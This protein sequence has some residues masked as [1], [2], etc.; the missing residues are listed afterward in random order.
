MAELGGFCGGR[1]TDEQWAAVEPHLL[2]KTV[3]D[4]G[5]GNLELAYKVKL[6]GGARKVIA[7]DCDEMPKPEFGGVKLKGIETHRSHFHKFM[8]PPGMLDVVLISWP[9]NWDL[10]IMHLL[11]KASKIIYLGCNTGGTACGDSVLFEHL[12]GREVLAHVPDRYNV[13]T[14]Y[15]SMGATRELLPEEH[16]A[17]NDYKIWSYTDIYGE[18]ECTPSPST[19]EPET[20][21]AP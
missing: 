3:F 9:C 19:T 5:A 20:P 4:L 7:I 14:T 18:N 13:L 8:P 15:G 12:A 6:E 1:F 2:D 10:E 17:L 21:E 11:R 16:A